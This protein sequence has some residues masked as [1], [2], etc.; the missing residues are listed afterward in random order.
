MSVV[1]LVR[2]V[3]G[4]LAAAMIIGM[5]GCATMGHNFDSTSLSWLTP[6]QTD[7]QELL[8][9]LGEPFRVGIDAGDQTWTYGF[10]KYKVFGTSTTKDL[11]IRFDGSGKVKSY[12]LNTSFPEEKEALEPTLKR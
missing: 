11:V 12:T 4:T 7:K 3:R 8:E 9:K 6:G 10:Y 5:A 1:T 2:K